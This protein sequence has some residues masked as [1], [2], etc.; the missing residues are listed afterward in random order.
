MKLHLREDTTPH[1]H[2]WWHIPL[3]L[4]LVVGT[5][6]IAREYN[7]KKSPDMATAWKPVEIQKNE[8]AVFGTFYHLTYRSTTNLQMSIDSVLAEV[9]HSLSPF[10]KKSII[11]AINENRSMQTDARFRHVFTLAQQVYEATGGAFDISVAPLVNAW[12]FGFKEG[13]NPSDA[14]ID[15]LRQFVGLDKV[16]LEASPSGGGMEGAFIVKADPRLM[17]DCSAIAKGY[18][19]DAVAD[20]LTSKGI[21]DFM[22]EIGGEIRVNGLNPQGEPWHIGIIRP[23]DDPLAN[24]N[25]IQQVVE[26]SNT[27]I[28]T[29]GNYRNFYEQDGQKVAHT[30]DPRTGHPVQLDILSATVLAPDCATADAFATAFMVVGLAEAKQILE[31]HPELQAYFICVDEE[32]MP[33]TWHTETIALQ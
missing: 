1:P 16:R 28:A 23:V 31:K 5:I 15:S 8:G 11:T 33:F 30:I 7:G 26:V 6:F 14:E 18:G 21:R 22:V 25:D 2:R 32:G 20:Y 12:G 3:L 13:K 27:A 4:L 19:V 29:S 24:N 17:L 10:N 9:D